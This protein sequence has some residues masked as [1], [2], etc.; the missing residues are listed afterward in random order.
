MSGPPYEQQQQRSGIHDVEKGPKTTTTTTRN[1]AAEAESAP[2]VPP[3]YVGEL[4]TTPVLHPAHRYCQR[5]GFVK[6]YRAH[7]CR[8]CGTVRSSLLSLF[9]I[10]TFSPVC[11]PIRPSLSMQVGCPNLTYFPSDCCSFLRDWAM[12]GCSES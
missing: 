2:Y 11:T 3:A 1:R 7:H 9:S 4:G 8:A 5:D 12:R 10:L 6:P